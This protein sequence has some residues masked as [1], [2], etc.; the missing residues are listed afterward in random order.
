M[1]HLVRLWLARSNW[2]LVPC[3]F[4]PSGM[5]TIVTVA[6]LFGA[7]SAIAQ[8]DELARTPWGH[9]DLQGVWD[10]RT[11]TPLERPAELVGR[12]VL[13]EEEAAAYQTLENQRQ[14]RDLVD[15]EKG[16]ALYPPAS[17]GGVVPYN[18]FWYDRGATLV[19]DRRT[20]LLVDPPDGRI[21][22]R[23]ADAVEQIGSAGEDLPGTRPVR[24]RAGSIGADGPEDR[25]LGE[26]C[27]LG[28]NSGPP[29][30]PSAYNNN[31][32]LF[33]TPTHVIIFHE[34]VHDARIVPLD[35]RPHL[36]E[37]LRQWMDDG[38]GW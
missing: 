5:V 4:L 26:R 16:G 13:S 17:E 20:A 2:W 31:V 38:R 33:Q 15:P 9:P 12:T 3:R 36:P 8:R 28:F 34:M 21:P 19:E 30:I 6:L 32:Q 25:G 24:Y 1:R 18:E 10:F 27:L 23:R 29:L 35:G 11:I 14:N 22:A 7:S 37:G